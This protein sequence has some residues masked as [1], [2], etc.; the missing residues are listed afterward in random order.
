MEIFN[1]IQKCQE[2]DLKVR[3]LESDNKLLLA[4]LNIHC[5]T[6]SDLVGFIGQVSPFEMSYAPKRHT[7]KV[8]IDT[9]SGRIYEINSMV[10]VPTK[11]LDLY[12]ERFNERT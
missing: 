1:S 9:L 8:P 12:M 2:L 6:I 3:N 10:P 7:L 5:E 11:E 4:R